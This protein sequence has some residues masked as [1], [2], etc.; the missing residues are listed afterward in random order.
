MS[1]R[2]ERKSER[3]EEEKRA[4]D[5]SR[6]PIPL[7]TPAKR[8]DIRLNDEPEAVN[9]AAPDAL[10]GAAD[11]Q[12]ADVLGRGAEHGAGREGDEREDQAD[13][14]A[15]DVADGA[16]HRHGHR[17]DEQVRRPDPEGLRRGSLEVLDY[18]L[19]VFNG[20]GEGFR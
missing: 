19:W 9:A 3:K 11:E 8:N 13:G 14:A 4:F 5:H 2:G 6:H 20:R 7:G 12:G 17:V 18:C 16:Y 10:D 15:E 1:W